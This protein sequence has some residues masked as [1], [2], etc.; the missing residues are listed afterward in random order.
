MMHTQC[1][2]V[3]LKGVT[4]FAYSWGN[5]FAPLGESNKY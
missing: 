1:K 4:S 2:Q 5:L 3:T